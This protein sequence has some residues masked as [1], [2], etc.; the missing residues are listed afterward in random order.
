M[1]L[2]ATTLTLLFILSTITACDDPVEPTR[3][4]QPDRDL[5][6]ATDQWIPDEDDQDMRDREDQALTVDQAAPVDSTLSADQMLNQDQ[7]CLGGNSMSR[8]P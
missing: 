4:G 6:V 3:Q 8:F 1:N 5:P 2:R 7:G